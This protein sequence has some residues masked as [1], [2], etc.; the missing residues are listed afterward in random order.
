[1][2]GT[3]QTVRILVSGI[4]VRAMNIQPERAPRKLQQLIPADVKQ[5]IPGTVQIVLIYATT[6]RATVLQ[7][8]TAH[9][10]QQVR[11]N[12]SADARN[13][14]SGMSRLYSAKQRHGFPPAQANLKIQSGIRQQA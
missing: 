2:L 7:I 10:Q 14:T 8:P 13:T 11:Q 3:V 4:H 5:I 1:M 12:T 9:A 6:I